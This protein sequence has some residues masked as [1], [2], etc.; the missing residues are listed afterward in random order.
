MLRRR[1]IAG[2]TLSDYLDEIQDST[3]SSTSGR[4]IE[5]TDFTFISRSARQIDEISS[6]NGEISPIQIHDYQEHKLQDN[7]ITS[8]STKE[9]P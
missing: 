3:V 2:L 6:S 1:R 9:G 7:T 4:P 8:T 5:L